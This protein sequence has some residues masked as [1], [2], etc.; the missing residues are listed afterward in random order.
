[1]NGIKNEMLA[2]IKEHRDE[3]LAV[4]NQTEEERARMEKIKLDKQDTDTGNTKRLLAAFDKKLEAEG[5]FRAKNEEDLRKYIESKFLN[6][7]D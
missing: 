5:Q 4:F 1:M 6:M 7:H 2:K 3:Y